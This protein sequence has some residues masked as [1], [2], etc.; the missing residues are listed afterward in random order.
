MRRI[1][2]HSRLPVNFTKMLFEDSLNTNFEEQNYSE[3]ESTICHLKTF[4]D[5]SHRRYAK[6]LYRKIKN[7]LSITRNMAKKSTLNKLAHIIELKVSTTT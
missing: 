2:N 3:L 4:S 6:M 7:Q 1:P 5:L